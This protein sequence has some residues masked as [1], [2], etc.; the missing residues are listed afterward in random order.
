MYAPVHEA[1]E[2][3]RV[4]IHYIARTLLDPSKSLIDQQSFPDQRS[5]ENGSE[6]LNSRRNPAARIGLERPNCKFPCL[7]PC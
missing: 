1:V 5:R 3:W 2:A 4:R 6:R 7:F